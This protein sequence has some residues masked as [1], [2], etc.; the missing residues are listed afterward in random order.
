MKDLKKYVIE[1]II[2]ETNL[3]KWERRLLVA[4]TDDEIDKCKAKIR[5]YKKLKR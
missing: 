4:L 2:T 5:Y 1:P 3:R